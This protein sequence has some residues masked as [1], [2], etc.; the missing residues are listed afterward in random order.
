MT[1][2]RDTAAID[3]TIAELQSQVARLQVF[4]QKFIATRDRLDRELQRFAGLHDYNTRA[5]NTPNRDELAQLTVEATV[6]IFETGFAL[7]WQV[8]LDGQLDAAPCAAEGV[9]LDAIPRSL[10]AALLG[11]SGRLPR[12]AK[13]WSVEQEPVLAEHDLQQLVL[14]PC[15]GPGG[16]TFAVLIAGATSFRGQFTRSFDDEQREALTL[17]S[18]Q[19]GAI[20]QNR[21]DS[22]VIEDQMTQLRLEQQRLSL[23]LEG[24]NAG[25]WDWDLTTNEVFFSDRWK[26]L[27]GHTPDE[28]P[29]HFTEWERLTHPED[30]DESLERVRAYLAGETEDYENVHRM[31]H[32][33]GHYVWIL[34]S[35]RVLRDD[36]GNPTRMVGIHLDITEQRLARERAEAANRA[37]TEFL[38]TMS[39]EIRT[40]MNGVLGM[41]QLLADSPLTPDQ[42]DLVEV[43]R[44]SADTLLSIIDDIL[45]LSKIEAGRV[46]LES[47]PFDPADEVRATVSPLVPRARDKGLSL[48][49]VVVPGL[50]RLLRGDARR[51]RQVVTNL[52]GNAVKFTHSGGITVTVGGAWLAPDRFD[53]A[54]S[55]A[56]TGI[57]IA[58]DSLDK[59]FTPFTQADATT[60]RVYG[61]TGL[62]LAIS[63][64]L[65]EQMSGEITVTST[66]EHGSTFVVRVP[67][68]P[69]MED[70]QTDRRGDDHV[71][72][73]TDSGGTAHSPS[74][75]ATMRVLV[76]EDNPI[77]QKVA[78]AMLAG[79]DSSAT[80]GAE[81]A[82]DI[83]DDGAAGVAQWRTGGDYDLILM[84]LQMPV[85]DGYDATRAIRAEEAELHRTRV[86][87]IALTATVIGADRDAAMA[88]GM[89]DFLAKPFTKAGLAD[90]VMRWTAGT[91][92][93]SGA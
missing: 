7:L 13:V 45:D 33:D 43:A 6:D 8:L 62:G 44:T 85:L 26:A 32:A 24:A 79:L 37:K 70:D 59:L 42:A 92:D 72:D 12:R 76:V 60:T 69:V 15:V 46:E 10:L 31:L 84:D 21:K 83:A 39:H 53:L 48:G 36:A 3:S 27:L 18:Q 9:D 14:A 93:T 88:A 68:P 30:V 47:L 23:A 17:F 38:A 89:D 57:G 56:D 19:V 1:E 65:M 61:G 64:R 91:S 87:I 11:N 51:L 55:V 20:L 2:A 35:G 81:L 80:H 86:P 67:L 77:N 16:D 73:L 22:R 52:V 74:A 54:I 58:A 40:P 34:A 90:V 41:L 29:N 50:P 5:L 75:P 71:A 82:I 63:R 25:L 28:I 66:P 49:V 4:Q 78:S